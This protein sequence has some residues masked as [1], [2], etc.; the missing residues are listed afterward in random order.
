MMSI[1]QKHT[2]HELLFD[3]QITYQDRYLLQQAEKEALNSPDMDTKVGCVIKTQNDGL[4]KACN[5]FPAGIMPMRARCTRPIKYAYI[6]HAERNAIYS[7]ARNGISLSGAMIYLTLFPCIDCARGI[8]QS[9]IK[10][11]VCRQKPD[12]S[13][14]KW[15]RDFVTVLSLFEEVNIIVLYQNNS[16]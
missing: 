12:L 14:E 9:G 16:D 3:K 10:R 2:T 6:E 5:D 13:D 4:I 15:G 11:L 8:I 7:A 1:E